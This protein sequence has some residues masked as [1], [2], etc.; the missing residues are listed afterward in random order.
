MLGKSYAGSTCISL[1]GMGIDNLRAVYEYAGMNGMYNYVNSQGCSMYVDDPYLAEFSSHYTSIINDEKEWG[2][3][4]KTH[5]AYFGKLNELEIANN[6]DFN[7][8][9]AKRESTDVIPSS[10][11]ILICQGLND[12]N[13][14]A[15]GAYST[16]RSFIDAE[17]DTKVILH[18]GGHDY[19][20]DGTGCFDLLVD[21]TKNSVL[22]NRW[23]SHYLFGA[24]NGVEKNAQH[25]VTIG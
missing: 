24:D 21:G 22:V 3:I 12:Y 7:S 19:L 13:V 17:M 11:T 23:F 8:E 4:S 5:M 16:Y 20:S 25:I 1:A 15:D 6:G 9:W 18:Q 10:T 2:Q 14:A